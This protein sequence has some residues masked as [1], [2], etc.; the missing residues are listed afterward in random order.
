MKMGD[1]AKREKLKLKPSD[2]YFSQETIENR[3]EDGQLIGKRLDNLVNETEKISDIRTVR[4]KNVHGRWYTLDNRRL[5]VFRNYQKITLQSYSQTFIPVLVWDDFESQNQLIFA[6]NNTGDEVKIHN[7]LLPGGETYKRVESIHPCTY[8]T[9]SR[10]LMYH[11]GIFSWN[12]TKTVASFL[13]KGV[14]SLYEYMR[15]R[16]ITDDSIV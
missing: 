4:V 10:L 1:H 14:S 5:W 12:G 7:G 15:R 11:I 16:E 2:V 6:A 9:P 8:S 3:F 13:W